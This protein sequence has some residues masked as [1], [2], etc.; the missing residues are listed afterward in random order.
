MSRTVT[1]EEVIYLASARMSIGMMQE[2]ITNLVFSIQA[3]LQV[4]PTEGDQ[5]KKELD[6]VRQFIQH[7][8]DEPVDLLA[9]MGISIDPNKYA[10][11]E[12]KAAEAAKPQL[13]DNVPDWGD[14]DEI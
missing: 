13:A 4:E 2:A 10:N 6:L 5:Q 3:T 8:I 7:Q 12:A 1:P 9:A 14:D 11:Q